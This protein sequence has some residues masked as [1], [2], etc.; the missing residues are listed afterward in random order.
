MAHFLRSAS[1]SAT[2]SIRLMTGGGFPIPVMPVHKNGPLDSLDS[3]QRVYC[4]PCVCI[5]DHSHLLRRRHTL[6]HG[7]SMCPWF[8][9][10]DAF[11]ILLRCVDPAVL[12]ESVFDVHAE[13]AFWLCHSVSTVSLIVCV[14]LAADAASRE[15]DAVAVAALHRPYAVVPPASVRHKMHVDGRKSSSSF[16]SVLWTEDGEQAWDDR[17]T[18]DPCLIGRSAIFSLCRR[19]LG[20]ES[21]YIAFVT[22]WNFVNAHRAFQR[23]VLSYRN[24]GTGISQRAVLLQRT[25]ADE[26]GGYRQLEGLRA[27][28][29][30]WPAQKARASCASPMQ[31]VP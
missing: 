26:P 5:G 25:A 20:D 15:Q 21:G 30:G 18:A 16:S 27:V 9:A 7:E 6:M 28:E 17:L 23:G 3:N 13:L 31:E 1:E 24:C 22:T 14:T 29:V 19:A 4:Y 10:C 12:W 11:C 8:F 2:T